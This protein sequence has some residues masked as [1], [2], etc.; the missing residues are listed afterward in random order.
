MIVI[1]YWGSGVGGRVV[2]SLGSKQEVL[3]SNPGDAESV[4]Q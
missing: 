1:D 3:G 2:K 4:G